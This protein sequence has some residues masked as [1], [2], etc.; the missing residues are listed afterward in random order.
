MRPSLAAISGYS[1]IQ[2]V[3]LHVQHSA[4]GSVLIEIVYGNYP[5]HVRQHYLHLA[6]TASAAF[7][8]ALLPGTTAVQYLPIL[9]HVPAWFPGGGFKRKV[10][11]WREKIDEHLYEPYTNAK[12]SMVSRS[13]L[14]KGC[15]DPNCRLMSFAVSAGGRLCRAIYYDTHA[16]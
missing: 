2:T 16:Y 4:N 12:K 15:Y 3:C 7:A 13:H 8:E 5:D 10:A 6:L 14:T 11:I 9:R 1:L